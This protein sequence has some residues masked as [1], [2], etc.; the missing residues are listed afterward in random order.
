[1]CVLVR[2]ILRL[3]NLLNLTPKHSSQQF[4]CSVNSLRKTVWAYDMLGLL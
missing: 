2:N 1:M 4:S 3:R